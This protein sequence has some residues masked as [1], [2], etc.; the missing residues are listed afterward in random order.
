LVFSVC[1]LSS[2]VGA[3]LRRLYSRAFEAWRIVKSRADARRDEILQGSAEPVALEMADE[4]V[5]GELGRWRDLATRKLIEACRLI[6]FLGVVGYPLGTLKRKGVDV[7]YSAEER[8]VLG[9]A[10]AGLASLPLGILESAALTISLASEIL[11]VSAGLPPAK[12]ATKEADPLALA[13]PLE[14]SPQAAA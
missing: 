5:S 4:L 6:C 10:R 9:K 8:M 2:E 3:D 14:A 7:P 13:V 1:G 12:E 11:R